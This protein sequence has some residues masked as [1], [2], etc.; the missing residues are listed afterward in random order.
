MTPGVTVSSFSSCTHVKSGAKSYAVTTLMSVCL[1]VMINDIRDPRTGLEMY[2]ICP[3][4]MN[5]IRN[6]VGSGFCGHTVDNSAFYEGT[7]VS[8]RPV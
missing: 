5:Q 6:W 2:M 7:S 8:A 3:L 1:D 4:N